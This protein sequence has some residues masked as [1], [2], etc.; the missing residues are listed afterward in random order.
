MVCGQTS[1][2]SLVM[3]VGVV[4]RAFMS[5]SV[6][7]NY[8]HFSWQAFGPVGVVCFPSPPVLFCFGSFLKHTFVHSPCHTY[9][10]PALANSQPPCRV[11][12]AR[13]STVNTVCR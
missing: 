3:V 4:L 6:P 8:V 2:Q 11:P 5:Q 9:F 1:V 7:G 12:C 10:L 13:Y